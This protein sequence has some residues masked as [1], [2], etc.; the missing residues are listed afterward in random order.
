MMEST[1]WPNWWQW[2]LLT[3]ITVNTIINVIVFFKH[4]FKRQSIPSKKRRH[5]MKQG[6]PEVKINTKSFF[7]D[8]KR[9]L[10]IREL[11]DRYNISIGKTHKLKQKEKEK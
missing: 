7:N 9:G 3:A 1:Y 10:T 2:W 11:A 5:K 6:R 8:V 4:R